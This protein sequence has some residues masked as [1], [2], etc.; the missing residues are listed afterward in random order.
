VAPEPPVASGRSRRA[1]ERLGP[2]AARS[3]VLAGLVVLVAVPVYAYVEPPWRPLVAR[4]AAALVL[5]VG[6]LQLRSVLVARIR[7]DGLSA[8][9]A[10]RGRRVPEPGVPHHF[11]DLVGD[12]RAALRSRRHFERVFWPRL[13]A[14]AGRPLPPPPLRPGRGPSLAG[15]RATLAALEEER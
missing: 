2:V 3:A 14:L 11:L 8:L 15:L 1:E 12:V 7:A 6:L 13:A 4:L 10:A 5:G 9:D